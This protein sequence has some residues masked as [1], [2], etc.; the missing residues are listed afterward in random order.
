MQ[1]HILFAS[2]I[3]NNHC[4]GSYVQLQETAEKKMHKMTIYITDTVNSF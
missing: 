2:N 4:K 1:K 3:V